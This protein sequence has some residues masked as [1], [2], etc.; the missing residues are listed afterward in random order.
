MRFDSTIFLFV[1]LPAALIVYYLVPRQ[2][3]NRVLVLMSVIFYAWGS[4]VHTLLILLLSFWNFLCGKRIYQYRKKPKR[5]SHVLKSGILVNVFVLIVGK[6]AG[7]IL[8]IAGSGLADSAF[9]AIPIGL[10]LIVLQSIAYLIDIY[11]GEE[12]PQKEFTNFAVLVLMFPKLIAGP[13]VSY[14]EF[15]PQLG[16]RKVTWNKAGEGAMMFVRGL[17]KKVLLGTSMGMVFSEIQNLDGSQV[18]VLTAWLGCISFALCLFFELDGYSDMSRGL[19]KLFGFE[20]PENMNMPCLATSIMDFWGRFF[21]TLWD[22]FRRY[23]YQAVCQVRPDSGMGFLYLAGTWILIGLWHG[24]NASFVVW[25]IYFAVLLFVEG[26]VLGAR[27][28]RLPQILRWFLTSVLLLISWVFFFSA[29]LGEAGAYLMRMVGIGGHGFT[30]SNAVSLITGHIFLWLVTVLTQIPLLKE[31]CHRWL[32]QA[33]K[34]QVITNAVVYGCLLVLCF[35]VVLTN[36]GD[37]FFYFRF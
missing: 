34:W 33:G 25:G 4:P 10:S 29:S 24:V 5:A 21:I 15:A 19:G 31:L 22:W 23:V 37:E 36:T 32:A 16:T 8:G 35:A 20:L 14:E 13:L 1:F 17:G 9:F 12:K 26:F 18:S 2:L 7:K 11:A 6:C 30:D 27:L 28:D 3:K